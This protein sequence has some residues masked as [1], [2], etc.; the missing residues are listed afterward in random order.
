MKQDTTQQTHEQ[1]PP[2]PPKKKKKKHENKQNTEKK[3]E[4]RQDEKKIRDALRS[5]TSFLAV[6]L[7][8]EA[9]RRADI[10]GQCG[11]Y[12]GFPHSFC[13]WFPTTL[14]QQ[15][16]FR[17]LLLTILS[18]QQQKARGKNTTANPHP[19]FVHWCAIRTRHARRRRQ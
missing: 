12:A 11:Y 7:S 1:P 17:H 8:S 4:R 15:C 5:L 3:N 9:T 18:L 13:Q 10:Y 16:I 2:P 14:L 6:V 19:T